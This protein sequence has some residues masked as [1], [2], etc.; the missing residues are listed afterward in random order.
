MG[1]M[2]DEGFAECFQTIGVFF[3]MVSTLRSAVRKKESV[4]MSFFGVCRVTSCFVSKR[5]MV[6][7]EVEM[8]LRWAGFGWVFGK[9]VAARDVLFESCPKGHLRFA[10]C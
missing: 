1:R 6:E 2:K 7:V 3:I 10:C 8:V 5:C 4:M 9:E